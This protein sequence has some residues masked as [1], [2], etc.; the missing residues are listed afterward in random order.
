MVLHRID[1]SAT[2]GVLVR[3]GADFVELP[4]RR[5]PGRPSTSVPFGALAGGAQSRR[6]AA[7]LAGHSY[8][9]C[10]CSGVLSLRRPRLGV[11]ALDVVLELDGLD[12][13]LL[14]PADLDVAQLA[15]T[16]RAPAPAA[17]E[18]ARISATSASVRKRRRPAAR[19]G[20]DVRHG[21]HYASVCRCFGGSRLAVAF[22]LWRSL[23]T[24]E[25]SNGIK[26]GMMCT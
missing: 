14:A 6:A 22:G 25:V 19:P 7:L 4:Q 26:L 21:A 18:V 8:R 9:R 20:R 2:R 16:A 12:A 23:W 10:R 13:V 17:T 3:V 1:G 15:A 24:S 11:H 5:G